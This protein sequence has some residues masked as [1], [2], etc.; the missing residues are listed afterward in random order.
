MIAKV[1][2][3]LHEQ[4]VRG[5]VA[6]AGERLRAGYTEE[7]LTVLLKR[8]DSIVEPRRPDPELRVED[9]TAADLPALYELNRRRG[10]PEADRY[11]ENSVGYGFHGFMAWIGEDPVG[12]YWWVDKDNATPHPDLWRLGKGFELSAGEVYGS[13]LFLLDEHRGGG[14]SG[15]F[16]Y[17]VETALRDRGYDR[18]WGYVERGNRA[19]LWLYSTRGYE[20]TWNMRNRRL[21]LLRWRHAEALPD[22]D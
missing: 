20:G 9:L 5:T 19:A 10:Q 14:R 4:G 2:R 13:S 3:N 8:L 15:A 21:V 22:S 1:R 6:R 18:L 17:R 11:F 12:Y 7:N 16:L